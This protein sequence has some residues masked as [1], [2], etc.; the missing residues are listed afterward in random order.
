M[1]TNGET[2]TWTQILDLHNGV[3][4]FQVKNGASTT[5]GPFGYSNMFKVQTGWAAR[6]INGYTPSVSVGQSGVAYAG[7]RV[8]SM[9]IKA[10]RLTFSDG[11][12]LTDNTVRTVH[13]L[14]D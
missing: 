14:V 1:Q 3:L 12:T 11:S 10:V 9:K 2:V 13:Q 6:N 5:W 8:Q 7:N 4:A